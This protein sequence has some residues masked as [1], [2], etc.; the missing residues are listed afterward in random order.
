MKMC[1][2][3]VAFIPFPLVFYDT[4]IYGLGNEIIHAVEIFVDVICWRGRL[5]WFF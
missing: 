2:H 3:F 5:D 4:I 1:E